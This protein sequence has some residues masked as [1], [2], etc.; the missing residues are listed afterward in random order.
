MSDN[1]LFTE[2]NPLPGS[3]L[4]EALTEQDKQ[5]AGIIEVETAQAN[6]QEQHAA[7]AATL[8]A[9]RW[10]SSLDEGRAAAAELPLLERLLDAAASELHRRRDE[11]RLH[12]KVVHGL[13]SELRE[14]QNSVNTWSRAWRITQAMLE[15]DGRGVS[16]AQIENDQAKF[17]EATANLARVRSRLLGC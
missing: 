6:I 13:A 5:T 3:P 1:E 16:Q 8:A 12:D 17:N 2:Y 15:S 4:H 10:D 9:L 7:A 14:A 11:K